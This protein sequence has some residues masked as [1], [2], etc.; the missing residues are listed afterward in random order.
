MND[1]SIHQT[2]DS[3]SFSKSEASTNFHYSPP[4]S[5]PVPFAPLLPDAA[6]WFNASRPN[7]WEVRGSEFINKPENFYDASRMSEYPNWYPDG[8]VN[9]GPGIPVRANSHA[10][11]INYYT[12]MNPIPTPSS[13]RFGLF[14]QCGI[15]S[16]QNPTVY[17][18]TPTLHQGFPC[19]Y[20]MEKPGMEKPFQGYQRPTPYGC[21]TMTE[22]IAGPRP[23]LQFLKEKEWQLQQDPPLR[24]P[25]FMGN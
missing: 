10:Q 4:Y 16:V 5:A 2:E 18:E 17:T 25:S 22:P 8:Q 9:Y 1:L 14:D 3:A 7:F 12:P 19:D 21:G 24:N 13:S 20:G 6:S 11:P 23:L 15:P